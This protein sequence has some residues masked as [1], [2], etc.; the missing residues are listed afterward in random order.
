VGLSSGSTIIES[1]VVMND[2]TPLDL[3]RNI[4]SDPKSAY[5]TLG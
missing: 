2:P 3:A 5:Q 4:S 1:V